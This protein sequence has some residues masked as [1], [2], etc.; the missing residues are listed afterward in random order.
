M[1]P[2]SNNGQ[3]L[4]I[5]QAIQHALNHH[6]AGQFPEAEAI[7]RQIL[8]AD[9]NQPDALHLLGAIA[10]QFGQVDDAIHLMER[11]VA[12]NNALA[13][14]HCNLGHLYRQ[15]GRRKKALIS[16]R[17]AAQLDP[18]LAEAHNGLGNLYMDR[19][20]LRKAT[21]CFKK[22]VA[23][24]PN[25]FEA[26]NNLGNVLA[27][28]NRPEEAQSH[29]ETAI[30]LQP[31]SAE[32][33]DNLGALY[34]S[35]AR[36]EAAEKS[37]QQ[38]IAA[39]PNYAPAFT[40]LA[41]L[42]LEQGA[43]DQ[44]LSA[45]QQAR[46]LLPDDAEP[47]M[48]VGLIHEQQGDFSA[49]EEGYRHAT[50]I[51][52]KLA[53][54]HNNRGNMQNR[55]GRLQEAMESYREALAIRPDYVEAHYNAA[56]TRRSLGQL[57]QAADSY[58]KAIA[59]RPHFPDAHNNLGALLSELG[60]LDEATVHFQRAL[61][62]R[63]NDQD[64]LNNLGSALRDQ[65]QLTEATDCY[66]QAIH[67]GGGFGVVK[68]LIST[69]LYT[70]DIDHETLFETSR[71]H[72]ARCAA[73]IGPKGPIQAPELA[74]LTD[75]TSGTHRLRVG[76]LSSDFRDHPVGHNIYPLL[77]LH[78][79]SK[80]DLY[81]YADPPNEDTMTARFREAALHWRSVRGWSS[82]QIAEKIRQDGIHIMVYLAGW[83]DSNRPLVATWRPAPIQVSFHDI[84]SSTLTE[85]DYWLSDSVLHPESGSREQFSEK[86]WRLPHFYSYPKLDKAPETAPP[87]CEKHG[88]ITFGSF[89]RL[90]KINPKVIALW[91]KILDRVPDSKLRLK[92]RNHLGSTPIRDA[93]R[94]AFGEH[95]IPSER[96]ILDRSLDDGQ[97]H[98]SHYKNVDIALDP[99]PFT[100]ATTT[101]QA[102]WMG[103][104]V[105]S[106]L[107][108]GFVHRMAGDILVHAG[109]SGWA[110]A[111]P[112]AYVQRA[113]SAAANKPLLR[114]MRIK[115]RQ[116]VRNS[117]L[118]D[119]P[120]YAQDVE[121][122]FVE[123]WHQQTGANISS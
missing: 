110:V 46:S 98:L 103:V 75:P 96:L 112:E 115:L 107:G 35:M 38:A 37:F 32:A 16:L 58:R 24:Q 77:A 33:H 99:F 83:M 76:Y 106:L 45:L 91:A 120:G 40:N 111:T 101:F 17:K 63:P 59:F 7:Y 105:I 90:T 66:R 89:N 6:Q 39:Q 117:V 71:E 118:C 5:P 69:M 97:A 81:C 9:P 51:D 102:L 67:N 19:D 70:P 61:K 82:H 113:V 36:W 79:P 53:K 47:A 44:A 28:Q 29:Y 108:D 50:E 3:T 11:A 86:L 14:A 41:R 57:E 4:S 31:Q 62:L 43:Y 55:L 21:A 54:A 27:R 10:Q 49:A 64:A 114:E 15:Q 119:G 30:T 60:R 85:M 20:K 65:G 95:G 80:V 84:A 22:A 68:N 73:R 121:R 25:L 87:P 34:L 92:Y 2:A 88:F 18:N 72:M 48:L 23:I 100:G 8:S 74:S 123:M 109:L 26:H 12:A 78:D 116:Q 122:A 93:L 52:P 1:A 13:P 42:H 104:P 56:H 94:G